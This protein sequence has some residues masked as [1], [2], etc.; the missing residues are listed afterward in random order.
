[1]VKGPLN[2]ESKRSIDEV[3]GGLS[4][5]MTALR[6]RFNRHKGM[7]EELDVSPPPELDR[8]AEVIDELA[9]DAEPSSGLLALCEKLGD[10]KG[11]V[12]GLVGPIKTKIED[13]ILFT[14]EAAKEINY[15][16]INITGLIETSLNCLVSPNSFL[17]RY[18][19]EEGG[20][21]LSQL[22]GFVDSH[23]ERVKVGRC[24]PES[25]Y[26]YTSMVDLLGCLVNEV[27]E[28]NKRCL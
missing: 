5:S 14:Q 16:F 18:V 17:V 10:L 19:G 27:L 25:S 6:E 9:V 12:D 20:H 22:Q 11:C 4:R 26:I 1:M 21:L 7:G 13:N 24:R 3:L 28:I 15:L 2:Y 8:V 23:N